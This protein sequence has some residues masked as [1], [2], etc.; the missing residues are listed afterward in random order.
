MHGV[1]REVEVAGCPHGIVTEDKCSRAL[2]SLCNLACGPR[3]IA[4]IEP[5]MNRSDSGIRDVIASTD[6]NGYDLATFKTA[7]K[8]ESLAGR[9][10]RRGQFA[11]HG[12]INRFEV[13]M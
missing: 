5:P 10:Q 6:M 7:Q 11:P 9:A 8:T 2:E 13:S 3:V 12:I 4:K 1:D